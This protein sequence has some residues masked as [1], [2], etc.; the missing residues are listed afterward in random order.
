MAAGADKISQSIE[1]VHL[2]QPYESLPQELVK[3]NGLADADHTRFASGE[4]SPITALK[5]FRDRGG[6]S[7]R[8]NI[9]QAALLSC[10]DVFEGFVDRIGP[11]PL[12]HRLS[13]L[14]VECRAAIWAFDQAEFERLK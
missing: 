7:L 3:Q 13:E 8:D 11:T 12:R 2:P 6:V 1:R 5:A 4:S 14:I 9:L 10:L